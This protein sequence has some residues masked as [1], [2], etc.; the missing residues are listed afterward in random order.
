VNLNS[1]INRFFG[2]DETEGSKSMAKERLR[3]VLV[4]DRLDVSEQVM[5][6][7]RVDLINLIG[8]YFGI[9][10]KAVE[11]SLSREADGM[12][13]IANI[14]IRRHLPDL[15]LDDQSSCN[16]DKIAAAANLAADDL[17]EKLI[18]EPSIVPKKQ[19]A[20][21][22]PPFL[23]LLLE[24]KPTAFKQDGGKPGGAKPGGSKQGEDKAGVSKLGVSKLSGAKPGASKPSED[25]AGVSK[26]GG[27]KPGASK[28]GEVKAGGSKQGGA[29][30][31]G[32]K[33][34]EDN[35]S[36]SKQGKGSKKK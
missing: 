2:R 20:P 10:E 4:H 13:L 12:A 15:S 5:N 33:P 24:K 30:P 29:K 27:A 36:G 32:S 31:G 1:I 14:P 11:V 34:G 28:P 18:D 6:A 19:A 22:K 16:G 7:L 25:K 23:D 17:S 9:D 21:E 26:L 8:K 3:L 35:S